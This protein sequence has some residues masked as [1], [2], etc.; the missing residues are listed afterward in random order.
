MR[1]AADAASRASNCASLEGRG[2]P[3]IFR[4]KPLLMEA[5]ARPVAGSASIK[6]DV[7][8][9]FAASLEAAL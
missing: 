3:Q 4:W 1:G 7:L 6:N 5:N 8:T 2:N 9:P